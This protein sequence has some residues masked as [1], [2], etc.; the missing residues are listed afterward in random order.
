MAF[1][2]L[3]ENSPFALTFEVDQYS[4]SFVLRTCIEKFRRLVDRTSYTVSVVHLNH[5]FN[6]VLVL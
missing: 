6:L 5:A 2:N 1:K 3:L 4:M